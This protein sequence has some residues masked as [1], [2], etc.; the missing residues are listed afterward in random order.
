MEMADALV[1]NKADGSNI[2]KA[3][4]AQAEFTNALH[5]FPPAPSGWAPL[6]KTCSS[7]YNSGIEEIWEMAESFREH[8]IE[9]G[10]LEKRR[11]EQS[12]YW[13]YETLREGIY[14]QVFHDPQMKKELEIHESAIAEGRMTSFMAASSILIKYKSRSDSR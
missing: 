13:M 7:I 4:R 2:Q 9:T 10:Y 14:N 5:L 3:K 11:K 6:V 1:I 12:R 8:C